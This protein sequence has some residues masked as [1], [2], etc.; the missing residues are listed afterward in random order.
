M[1][2]S[3]GLSVLDEMNAGDGPPKNCAIA[4]ENRNFAQALHNFVISP[5]S[6]TNAGI[7][8]RRTLHSFALGMDGNYVPRGVE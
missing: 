4:H 1:A 7:L 3:G 2:V 8:T 6:V 5:V